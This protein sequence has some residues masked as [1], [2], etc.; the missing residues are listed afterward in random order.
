MAAI[1]WKFTMC[2]VLCKPFKHIKPYK[3]GS[4]YCLRY[5]DEE[6]KGQNVKELSQDQL[7]S[8]GTRILNQA[9]LTLEPD[10]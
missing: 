9:F 6:T 4:Y 2:Q 8:D 1:Y 5:S 7:V 3:V 10:F